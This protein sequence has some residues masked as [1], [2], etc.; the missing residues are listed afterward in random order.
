MPGLMRA[1]PDAKTYRLALCPRAEAD[2]AAEL[3]EDVRARF[4]AR[5]LAELEALVPRRRRDRAAGRLAAKRALAAH[6]E[7]EEGWTPRPEELELS[8]DAAGR[9]VLRLP[10]GAPFAVPHFS[11]SH[12]AEGGAAAVGAGGRR[13]GVDLESVVA[14]P[15]EVV[16]FVA[17]PGEAAGAPASDPEAQAR[18]WTGKEAALKLLGLGLDADARDVRVESGTARFS[19]MPERAWRALGAP[20]VS[21]RFERV[22]A[23]LLAV[24][25]TEEKTWTT[26]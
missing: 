14:R 13:V 12:A 19:G 20:R 7:A 18:L 1:I 23:A 22:G 3:P 8:N 15:A 11:I 5:E 6:F 4:S 16:A 26:I 2:R 10:R 17:A 21:V 25:C 24:A 9:P